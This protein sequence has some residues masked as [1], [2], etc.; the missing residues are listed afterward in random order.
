[1]D[2]PDTGWLDVDKHK[3]PACRLNRNENPYGAS[4]SAEAAARASLQES[5]RYPDPESA[6]L[7]SALGGHYD[8]AATNI[9]VGNGLDELILLLALTVLAD[10]RPAIVTES[11]FLSYSKSLQAVEKPYRSIPLKDYRISVDALSES[12]AT[13]ASIAF[14]CNPHNPTGSI[15]EADGVRLLCET[16]QRTG[17]LLVMDEAYAEYAESIGTGFVSAL[18]HARR[19][20]QVCVLRTFSKAYG[21]AGLRAGYAVGHETII[22]NVNR[23][24]QA[25]PFNLSR[26]A[27]SAAHQALQDQEYLRN[28]CR[29]NSLGLAIMQQGLDDLG[30]PYVPSHAN[31]LLLRLGGRSQQV[32]GRLADQGVVVNDAEAMGMPGHIRMAV[33]TS[34]EIEKLLRILKEILADG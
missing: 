18:P 2:R 19:L 6:A 24:R 9:A 17:V 8:V 13:G 31:F 4:P 22:A 26:V 5:H 16:A 7:R 33:G 20:S 14:V 27:Q 3:I 32:I 29:E 11:T 23:K 1:M 34:A 12:F 10:P 15:L 21:L 25:L 30:I 28:V